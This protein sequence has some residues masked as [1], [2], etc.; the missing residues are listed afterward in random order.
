M[1]VTEALSSLQEALAAMESLSA[2]VQGYIEGEATPEP[3]TAVAGFWGLNPLPPEMAQYRGPI[4]VITNTEYAGRSD[5]PELAKSAD[6]F[7]Q[8][9]EAR[10]Y[11]LALSRTNNAE[12]ADFIPA[13]P[14]PEVESVQFLY[15]LGHGSRATLDLAPSDTHVEIKKFTLGSNL[16]WLVVDACDTL[17]FDSPIVSEVLSRWEGALG[18]L[19]GVLGFAA[20]G[21]PTQFRGEY[22]ALY[23]AEGAPFA[24]A[25]RRACEETQASPNQRWAM[26]LVERGDSTPDELS[27]TDLAS[28]P[29][30]IGLPTAVYFRAG[31]A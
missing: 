28:G 14:P 9:L 27:L 17:S 19:H 25:W 21:A 31:A 4:G 10:G 15:F 18:S 11:S 26:L 7:V 23:L 8:A 5:L 3:I 2:E 16:R 29:R 13:T 20:V 22:L 6:S 30:A 12:V 1:G 24:E